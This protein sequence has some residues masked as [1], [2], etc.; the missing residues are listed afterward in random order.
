[1]IKDFQN[2]L[3]RKFRNFLEMGEK[4][5]RAGMLEASA[6]ALMWDMG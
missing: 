6:A 5:N 3:S 2:R 1:M 4:N